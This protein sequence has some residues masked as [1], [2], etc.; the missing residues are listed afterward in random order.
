MSANID[1]YMH[2]LSHSKNENQQE[3]IPVGCI[4]S[5]EV[6][7]SPAMHATPNLP[8]HASLAAHAPTIHA[9]A[10]PLHTPLLPCIPPAMY[11]PH[12]T[13]PHHTCPCHAHPLPYTTP[14]MY[15]PPPCMPPCEQY[16]RRL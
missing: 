16:H 14:P 13:F 5:A 7:V 12:H 3:S 2:L 11:A 10:T 15:T 6:A 1:W 9:P 4:L 8:H